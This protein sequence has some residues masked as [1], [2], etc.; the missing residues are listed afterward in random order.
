MDKVLDVQ[1]RARDHARQ[2]VTSEP[3]EVANLNKDWV[4]RRVLRKYAHLGIQL[5]APIPRHEGAQIR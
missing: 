5:L 4:H 1:D 2:L 3:F